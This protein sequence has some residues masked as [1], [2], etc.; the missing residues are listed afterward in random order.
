[1]GMATV[2]L[3][4][5]FRLLVL[6]SALA[7][8]VGRPLTRCATLHSPPHVP[9]P[10]ERIFEIYEEY[11]PSMGRGRKKKKVEKII[12]REV[13]KGLFPARRIHELYV[14]MCAKDLTP[15]PTQGPR[16]E[17]LI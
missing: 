11:E 7:L 6:H 14:K 13:N 3:P 4:G 5:C 15:G 8:A 16:F 9:C 10:Q 1:M 17:G 2:P 12:S